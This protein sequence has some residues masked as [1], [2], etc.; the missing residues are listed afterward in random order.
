[1]LIHVN[2]NQWRDFSASS[3]TFA[4]QLDGNLVHHDS[5]RTA[6]TNLISCPQLPLPITRSLLS[7]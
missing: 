7:R 4:L 1:M 5:V 3:L 6:G 2:I